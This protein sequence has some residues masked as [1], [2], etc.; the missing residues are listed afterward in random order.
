VPPNSKQSIWSYCDHYSS[1]AV[2]TFGNASSFHPG[3]VNSLFADGSV[4]FNK[5]SIN[6]DTWWAI[7]TKDGA[8][9]VGADS[10]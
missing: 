10:F 4:R 1:S 6:Q 7:G 3:G 8:E 5:D 2:G 9:V